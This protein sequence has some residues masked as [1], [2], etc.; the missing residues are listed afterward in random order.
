MT[1][2]Y[3]VVAIVGITAAA[4]QS[5]DPVRSGAIEFGISAGYATGDIGGANVDIPQVIT[6]RMEGTR[7]RSG[8]LFLG[9]GI[10]PRYQLVAEAGAFYGGF[11][12]DD[13]G[14][15]FTAERKT[16]ALVYDTCLHVRFPKGRFVPYVAAGAGIVQSRATALILFRPEPGSSDTAFAATRV[17]VKEGAFAPVAGAGAQVYLQKVRL[18]FKFEAKSFFPTGSSKTPFVQFTAGVLTWLK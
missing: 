9:L 5:N 7:G 15:G 11:G 1:C 3:L 10:R 6:Y 18:G 12:V 2:R 8:K 14:G 16:M 17:Q 4:G 13:L